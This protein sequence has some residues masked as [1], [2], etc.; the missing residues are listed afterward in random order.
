MGMADDGSHFWLRCRGDDS[1]VENGAPRSFDLKITPW[2]EATS[3][4]A[5]TNNVFGNDM[6]YDIIRLHASKCHGMIDEQSVQGS[7]Y[8]QKVTVQ[9]PSVPW[10]WGILHFSEG[11]Y[12]DWFIPHASLSISYASLLSIAALTRPPFG[13]EKGTNTTFVGSTTPPLETLGDTSTCST[14]IGTPSI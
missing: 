5:Y 2:T 13:N 10:F 12:L 1:A 4:A 9:A 7:A 14:L 3:S 8:F 11:T 6:G